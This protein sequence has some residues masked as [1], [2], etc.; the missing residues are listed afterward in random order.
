MLNLILLY[1]ASTLC[2][3]CGSFLINFLINKCLGMQTLY[4]R[5]L[6]NILNCHIIWVL[7][8]TIVC[9]LETF[10]TEW[11]TTL[12]FIVIYLHIISSVNDG[13]SLTAVAVI[14]YLLVFHGK[15][16]YTIQDDRVMKIVRI[17]HVVLSFTF[18][19]LEFVFSKENPGENYFSDPVEV[20]FSNKLDI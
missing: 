3:C 17:V 9:S 1:L 13:L 4:D 14:R 12:H 8:F 2:V 18:T 5:I 15:I 10:V 16:F 20:S 6:V 7:A 11:N 19:S